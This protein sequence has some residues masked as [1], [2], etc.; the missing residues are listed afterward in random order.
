MQHATSVVG[1]IL[2]WF[3]GFA[4]TVALVRHI[5]R[6]LCVLDFLCCAFV[7]IAWPVIA[8]I[9][10]VAAIANKAPWLTDV[11]YLKRN[12]PTP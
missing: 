9:S 1:P 7:A 2:Y 3:I 10:L 5:N 8:A 11:R 6:G 4:F 12:A